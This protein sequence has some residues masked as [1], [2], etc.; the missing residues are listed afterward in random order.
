LTEP[1]SL[2][3]FGCGG[4][5]SVVA[6][7]ARALGHRI[8]IAIDPDTSP[9]GWHD[10]VLTADDDAV[11]A[12]P[13]EGLD[14]FVNGL[15]ANPVIAGRRALYERVSS[16]LA[17]VTLVHPFT[18]IDA[19]V[20]LGRGVQV[21]AGAIV[22]CG[23]IVGENCVLNTGSL[24]DHDCRIGAHAFVSPGATLCGEVD[25]GED[26]FIG[27]A[28]VVMPGCEIGRRAIIGMGAVVTRSV[29]EGAIVAGNPAR[30]RQWAR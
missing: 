28:S 16:N 10:G 25:V 23:A 27:A 13:P 2:A 26:A 7:T 4:H 30:T 11:L 19:T 20:Q 6:A 8:V 14:G 29:P 22:Q 1:L 24:I 17:P 21:M 9:R 5:G 18:S 15:G 12:S 3:L